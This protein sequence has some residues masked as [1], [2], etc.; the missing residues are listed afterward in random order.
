MQLRIRYNFALSRNTGAIFLISCNLKLVDYF[1][2]KVEKKKKI[3]DI[4][5][6]T[7]EIGDQYFTS[8]SQ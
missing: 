7:D 3:E 6:I 1:K 8:S 5:T 4:K 2:T